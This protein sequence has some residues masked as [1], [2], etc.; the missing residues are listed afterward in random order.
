MILCLSADLPFVADLQTFLEKQH[1]A[2]LISMAHL[3]NLIISLRP[4]ESG[5]AKDVSGVL[6]ATINYNCYPQ[7]E[8]ENKELLYYI[9]V[10]SNIKIFERGQT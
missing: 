3:S 9:G 7:C 8:L 2:F 10:D 4:L 5:T 1:G 6:R